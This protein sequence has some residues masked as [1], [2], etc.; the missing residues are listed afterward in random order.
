MGGFTPDNLVKAKEI[1]GLYPK[2]RS[3]LIP[4]CHLAQSQDG[5]LT[6]EAIVEIADLLDLAPAE[7]KG[8]AS[9]YDMLHTEP[10]GRYLVGVCTN[11]ACMLGGAYELLEHC[12]DRLGIRCGQTTKDGKFTLEETECM[13]GCDG[14]PCVTVNYRY[15]LGLDNQGIDQLV[16]DLEAGRLDNEIPPHGTV[17]RNSRNVGLTAS[18]TQEPQAGGKSSQIAQP[19]PTKR[20]AK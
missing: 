1:I 2:A 19:T 18:P 9:F 7:V 13:A 14:P 17:Y 10:V 4:L 3:A 6:P 8:T 12:E 5:W 20:G 11:I 16:D 15:F